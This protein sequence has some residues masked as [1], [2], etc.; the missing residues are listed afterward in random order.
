MFPVFT[1]LHASGCGLMHKCH[2]HR[3]IV[4]FVL[5]LNQ[6]RLLSDV[7][8]QKVYVIII[9]REETPTHYHVFIGDAVVECES[10]DPLSFLLQ[11]E[12]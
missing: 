1:E 2:I 12:D 4:L 8:G 11:V 7:C 6:V 10:L 9:G 5:I 3:V